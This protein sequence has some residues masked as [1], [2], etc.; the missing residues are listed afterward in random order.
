[1][2]ELE[3]IFTKNILLTAVKVLCWIPDNVSERE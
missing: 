3:I 2:Q 1:M